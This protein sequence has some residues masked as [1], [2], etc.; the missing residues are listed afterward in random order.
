[1]K[2][3]IRLDKALKR[4][5][6]L[7][8]YV[9]PLDWIP[10]LL[11]LNFRNHVLFICS[12]S[13]CFISE[14]GSL[15]SNVFLP[16]QT[17]LDKYRIGYTSLLWR[18]CKSRASSSIPCLLHKHLGP[19]F[20]SKIL[21][22]LLLQFTKPEIVVGIGWS[23]E[24]ADAAKTL[25]VPLIEPIHGFG[26]SREDYV[27]GINQSVGSPPDVFIVFDDITYDTLS[28]NKQKRFDVIRCRHSEINAEPRENVF[29]NNQCLMRERT[30]TVLITLQHGYDGTHEFLAGILPNGFI[31]NS[32]LEVIKTRSDLNWIIKAHPAQLVSPR[33]PAILHSLRS[34]LGSCAHVEFEKYNHESTVSLLGRCDL[35]ITMMSGTIVEADLLGVPSIG[36]CPT[37]HT[38]GIAGDAFIPQRESGML[39]CC[40]LNAALISEE[41]DRLLKRKEVANKPYDKL[42]K[43]WRLPDAGEVVYGFLGKRAEKSDKTR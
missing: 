30:K 7:I 35:H 38:S 36:L 22:K 21:S 17:Y 12:P 26:L 24:F 13:D 10:N 15:R 20:K 1:M 29:K 3:L 9:W 28:S 4:I 37:L 34:H 23:K 32:L 14:N 19:V 33:W 42:T 43:E 18:R 27:Y 6:A 31:H 40:K 5:S 16:I 2:A 41:I 39:V 25:N 8:D 11:S